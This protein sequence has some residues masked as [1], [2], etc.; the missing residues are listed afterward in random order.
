MENNTGSLSCLD[1]YIILHEIFNSEEENA[2]D[3]QVG[4]LMDDLWYRKLSQEEINLINMMAGDNMR[5]HI[6]EKM[7][8]LING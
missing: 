4:S 3:I 8:G 6:V 7:K 2:L 5:H 1:I